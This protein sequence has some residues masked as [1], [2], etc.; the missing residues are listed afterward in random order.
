MGDTVAGK[1]A[2]KRTRGM[3]RTYKRGDV[4]WIEY[5][6][7]GA[8]HR[9]STGSTKPTDAT[10][11]LKKRLGEI[12]RGRLVGPT[13]EKVTF[14]DMAADLMQHRATRVDDSQRVLNPATGEPKLTKPERNAKQRIEH[15][16]QHF[17]NDRAVDITTDRVRAFQAARLKEGA[18][19][20]TVNRDCAALSKM[21]SLSVQA[22]RL[23]AKPHIPHLKESEP[24][25]GFLDRAGYLAIRAKLTTDVHQDVL[26]FMFLAGWRVSEVLAL[27]WADVNVEAGE[28]RL[29]P[30]LSKNRQGRVLALD[31][32]LADVIER[33]RAAR[34]LTTPRIF[35]FRGKE[36]RCWRKRW[37][38]ACKYAGYSGV[39]RH[40]LRRAAV[41]NLSRAGVTD[42]VAM[43]ITGHKTRSV[44]DRYN[45]TSGEDQR[46]AAVRLGG[47]LEGLP[48][49]TAVESMR[50]AKRSRRG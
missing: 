13:Q 27:E 24:R 1:G 47:Y 16:R 4:W 21:F 20:A 14:E 3:G 43:S 35:H 29:R 33:R 31:G 45:I 25:Q 17:G 15:L 32:P 10:A 18:S 37:R 36:I 42:A 30:E 19:P 7:R 26:D 6:H 48:A 12:G 2:T 11:L 5:W 38:T 50:G 39:L 23:N 46:R 34:A 22:G 49:D 28:I 44:Y 8:Q 41:R 9:E 40:D